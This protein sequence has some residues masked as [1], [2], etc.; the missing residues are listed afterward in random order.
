M[1]IVSLKRAEIVAGADEAGELIRTLETKKLVH[2]EDIHEGLPE[3]FAA[4]ETPR[5]EDISVVEER[6]SKARWMLDV[7]DRFRPESKSML[8]S[9][10]GSVPYV[11]E[12]AF[13]SVVA[14]FDFQ[15]RYDSLRHAY[16][17]YEKLEQEEQHLREQIELIQPWVPMELPL[18]ALKRRPYSEHLPASLRAADVPRLIERID[19]EGWTGSIAFTKVSESAARTYGVV[20]AT[21]PFTDEAQDALKRLGA[22][23]VALPLLE[24]TPRELLEKNRE[25]LRVVEERK[26]EL[27]RQFSADADDSRRA[28]EAIWDDAQNARK[29]HQLRSSLYFAEHATVMRG[30]VQTEKVQELE[31]LL[32]DDARSCALRLSDPKKDENPPVILKN[33]RLVQPFELLIDMF[34]TPRYDGIDPT[35]YTAGAMTVFYGICLGDAGYGV[36]QI[37]LALLLKRK[38]RPA[39][40]TRKF[41]DM[42]MIMGVAGT[43]F[44]ILTWT[45]FGVSPGYTAGGAKLL[46]FLPLLVPTTDILLILGMA[47]GIGVL[48][49]L[50][51]IGVGFF[52]NLRRGDIAAAIGDNLSWFLLL[53]GGPL[54]GAAFLVPGL[55]PV[56]FGYVGIVLA[57]LAVL[58]VL[59]FSGRDST[60]IVARLLTGVVA[61]YGI[62]GYY[63]IVTFASDVLSY[64]RLA[65]L[66]LTTGYIA[67]VGNMIGTLLIGGETLA[68]ILSAV[69]GG[70]IIGAFHILN[71]LISMLGSFVHSLRLNYLESYNRFP[72]SGGKPF[73]PL[74]R[75]AKFYRFEK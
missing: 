69:V 43:L 39:I 13:H 66:N 47:I 53:L 35:P 45:F 51:A 1:A 42:F 56:A 55:I 44:G 17:E 49:Q 68:L 18:S 65:I 40:G 52:N 12:Q 36:L 33:R 48:F 46:G 16:T 57:G 63:G 54:A 27:A 71:L 50:I 24:E 32:R 9:F 38:F 26:A 5:S 19:T 3:E 59:A 15:G 30:W 2:V 72:F 7:Y 73:S 37:L 11:D 62:V 70:V 31:E 58:G 25:R 60:N 10:F 34:G 74:K 23:I 20:T 14:G 41:L 67:M 75:E 6:A 4:S 64:M 21:R 28:V 22:D 29:N 8:E 61:F